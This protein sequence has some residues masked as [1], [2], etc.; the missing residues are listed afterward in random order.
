MAD[1]LSP[2]EEQRA[3]H[4]INAAKN[5]A[6]VNTMRGFEAAHIGAMS[7]SQQ[8]Q[9]ENTAEQEM[10]QQQ[11]LSAQM[12]QAARNEAQRALM[13]QEFD[14][15]A[16]QAAEES[17][18]AIRATSGEEESL[19][20]RKTFGAAKKKVEFLK[21]QMSDRLEN[22]AE[23][24]GESFVLSG[25]IYIVLAI[26]V[27]I[28]IMRT[29]LVKSERGFVG[30]AAV[31]VPPYTLGQM[32]LACVVVIF[33]LIVMFAIF[34]LVTIVLVTVLDTA[35]GVMNLVPE[36][37]RDILLKAFGAIAL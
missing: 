10:M 30:L 14:L 29:I 24:T 27:V 16:A 15:V 20:A 32:L 23:S 31:L 7:Q 19:I 35:S 26:W 5:Q 3:Q 21:Q 11:A 22:L 34:G 13:Q 4:I 9:G 18:A 33:G 25:M 6:R 17:D 28:R 2:K 12:A 8:A 1:A 36:P 37:F